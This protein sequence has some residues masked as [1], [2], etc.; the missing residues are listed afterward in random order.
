MGCVN[1]HDKHTKNPSSPQKGRTKPSPR[2][3]D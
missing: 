2:K 3:Q 1:S